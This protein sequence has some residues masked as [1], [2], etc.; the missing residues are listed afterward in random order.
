MHKGDLIRK[1]NFYEAKRKDRETQNKANA[2][3]N[4]IGKEKSTLK[5]PYGKLKIFKETTKN[6]N[7]NVFYGQRT[8]TM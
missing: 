6:I 5:L 4:E 1:Q 2:R 3:R 7:N 8:V